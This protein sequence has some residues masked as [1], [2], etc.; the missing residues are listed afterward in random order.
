MGSWRAGCVG[1]RTS[2]SEVRAGETD[3]WKETH[4]APARPLPHDGRV[5]VDGRMFTSPGGSGVTVAVRRGGGFTRSAV[6]RGP[7]SDGC[8]APHPT[9][10]TRRQLPESPDDA[11]EGGGE[12]GELAGLEGVEEGSAHDVDVARVHAAPHPFPL[13]RD[14]G[15]DAAFVVGGALAGDP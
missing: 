3:A 10:R 8:R 4:R 14:A 15:D 13:G 11:L 1:T 12:R 6:R 7:R 5:V 2:G 9:I